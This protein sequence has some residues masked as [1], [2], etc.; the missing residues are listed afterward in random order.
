MTISVVL[1]LFKKSVVAI[2]NKGGRMRRC[3]FV[4]KLLNAQVCNRVSSL[5]H[6][7]FTVTV[8]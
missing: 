2:L 6:C 7:T 3:I 8:D 1:K 4:T 5:N